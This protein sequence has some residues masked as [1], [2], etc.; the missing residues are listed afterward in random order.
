MD[1]EDDDEDE[2]E[3][4]DE[5]DENVDEYLDDEDEESVRIFQ[6]P[7][8]AVE[9]QQRHRKQKLCALFK[10]LHLSNKILLHFLRI[11][12]SCI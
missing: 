10:N 11:P 8:L 4:E 5:D 2:D 12:Y 7:S 9:T 1:G 3:V 6:F